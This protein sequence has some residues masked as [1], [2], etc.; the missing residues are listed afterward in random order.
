MFK[1]SKHR[2]N[3]YIFSVILIELIVQ[4]LIFFFIIAEL[5]ITPS[6]PLRQTRRDNDWGCAPRL[7]TTGLMS[8]NVHT[9]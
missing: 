1:I 7:G 8:F 6:A 3:K 5:S 9:E 4:I 2:F